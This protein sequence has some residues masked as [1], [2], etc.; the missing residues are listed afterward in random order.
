MSVIELYRLQVKP[1]TSEERLQLARWILDD[2]VEATP[3]PTKPRRRSLMELEGLGKEIWAGV[4]VEAYV[5]E[6]RDEWDR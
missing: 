2:L 3:P 4:D 6:L 5:N 1:L